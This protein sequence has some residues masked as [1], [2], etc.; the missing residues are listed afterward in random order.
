MSAEVAATAMSES[1]ARRI[2]GC[3]RTVAGMVAESIEKL[4]GLIREAEQGQAHV[5]LG[6]RSWTEYVAEEFGGMLPKL[7]RDVRREFVGQLAESG[8]STRAIA[9]VVGV[10]H[11]TVAADLKPVVGNPTGDDAAA[12]GTDVPP[13]KDLTPDSGTERVPMGE[14]IDADE[15]VDAEIV[16][17][18]QPEPRRITGRDG[19]NYPAPTP[20]DSKPRRRPFPDA[21]WHAIYELQK[22]VER[23]ERLHA[24][25]RF[26]AHREA[27][28]EKHWRQV[29]RAATILDSVGEDLFGNK[30]CHDCDERILPD[31]EYEKRCVTCRDG[32]RG[33]IE[34]VGALIGLDGRARRAWVGRPASDVDETRG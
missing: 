11:D 31:G 25:D 34:P 24:D 27:V 8:M 19:K 30:K 4:S 33:L 15:V 13:V 5:A 17:D 20:R 7:D 12:G 22:S 3:I 16:E 21:Y 2:T 23:I 6:Y 9:G 1:D 28:R 10:H 14:S 29:D 18:E 26:L 32:S